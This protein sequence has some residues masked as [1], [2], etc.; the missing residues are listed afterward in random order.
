MQ[1][2][3]YQQQPPKQ[4]EEDH[5][6]Q[7]GRAPTG[8]WHMVFAPNA[9]LPAFQSWLPSLQGLLRL[10]YPTRQPDHDGKQKTGPAVVPVVLSDYCEEA[11][12]KSQHMV[13]ALLGQEFTLE[14]Y[15]NPFRCPAPAEHGTQLPACS[16]GFLFGWL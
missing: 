1:D 7:G 9:G 12:T 10:A 2:T 4:L 11:A 6:Q 13:T 16:S 15:L 5:P 3:W 14:S 8:H